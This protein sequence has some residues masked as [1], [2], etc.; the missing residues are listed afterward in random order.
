MNHSPS[1]LP[2]DIEARLRAR[3]RG[4]CPGVAR[5]MESGDGLLV[6]AHP[7][8]GILSLDQAAGLAAAA[9]AAGNGR[10]DITS[11]GNAQIRGV[12]PERHGALRAR[13]AAL[14]LDDATPRPPF[15]ATIVSPLAD[16]DP[17]GAPGA[18]EL[19]D[20]VEAL[21]HEQVLPPKFLVVLETGPYPVL[22][23]L[24]GDITLRLPA[25]GA[26][27]LTLARTHGAS[28]PIVEIHF[29][30]TA[31]EQVLPPLLARLSTALGTPDARRVRALPTALRLQILAETGSAL[32]QGGPRPPAFAP[33]VGP[34]ALRAGRWGLIAAAPSGQLEAATLAALAS[35][36]QDNGLDGIRLTPWRGI[37]LHGLKA[38]A[39]PAATRALADLGLIIDGEDPRLGLLTC[40]GAPGCTHALCDSRTLATRL[41]Q[42]WPREA[43]TLHLSACAKGCARRGP[44][45]LTLVAEADGFAVI[46]DGGPL[47]PPRAHLPFADILRR[48]S[49]HGPDALRAAFPPLSASTEPHAHEPAPM[50]HDY[51][52]SGA[53]IYRRSFAIIRA[54]ADLSAWSGTAERVVV[55]MIHACGMTDLP[56]DVAMSDTFAATAEAALKAGAPILCDARM[57]AD[58]ITRARLPAGNGVVCTLSDP[59]TPGLA[60]SLETTRSAAALELWREQIAG[61]VVAVG[62]APSA[63]FRLLE[64]FDQGWPLP[65]AIIGIPVGFVGAAESKAAL[66]ADGRVPFLVVRGRRG[67]SAMAA[68][69][70]NALASPEE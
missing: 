49:T 31:L 40:T 47:D 23:H 15:R 53:E 14:G 21:V 29:P 17:W 12:T 7:R 34:L 64:L 45:A 36:A 52:K 50:S 69:A 16:L 10:I 20:R 55:R 46:P 22:G 32:V 51:L 11:H 43:G 28:E 1:P 59:R 70:V 63:L 61:A 39:L 25:P 8:H 68:A 38:E 41:A 48:L 57:V 44:A 30:T 26:L 56:A 24:G 18:L 19:A 60:Q 67:G 5:P 65:A 4:W 42:V 66:E 3:A 33:S 37:L 35:V 58:G 9:Q 13:L 54:E 6:R 2:S 27:A 62:N